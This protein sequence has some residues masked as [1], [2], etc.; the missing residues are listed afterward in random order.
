LLED[1]A[2]AALAVD[3]PPGNVAVVVP[4]VVAK[5]ED[6]WG[7]EL[8]ASVSSALEEVET[9]NPAAAVVVWDV[10][11]PGPLRASLL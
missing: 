5:R 4:V 3:V 11:V 1:V 7:A 10:P 9:F 8:A 6:V 2:D